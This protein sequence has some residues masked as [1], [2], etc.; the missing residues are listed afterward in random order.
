MHILCTCA[1]PFEFF[2][3]R[4]LIKKSFELWLEH[5]W[6]DLTQILLCSFLLINKLGALNSFWKLTVAKAYGIFDCNWIKMLVSNTEIPA[7]S[8][9]NQGS[10]NL[11]LKGWPLTV[12]FLLDY[13]LLFFKCRFNLFPLCDSYF[14]QLFIE[15]LN[16]ISFS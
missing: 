10:N 15:V 2:N 13:F 9:S 3:S 1:M 5:L 7:V 16:K 14:W 12:S 11:T 4:I 8:G 6:R